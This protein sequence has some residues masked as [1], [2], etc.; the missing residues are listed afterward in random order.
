MIYH[1]TVITGTAKLAG[2]DANIFIEIAGEHGNTGVHR[3]HN[4]KNKKEF[5]RSQTDHFHVNKF[6]ILN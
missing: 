4:S 6:L 1:I 2:T 5:E 3:L